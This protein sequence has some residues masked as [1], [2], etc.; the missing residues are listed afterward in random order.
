[1][2]RRRPD[3]P[4]G[5]PVEPK[6]IDLRLAAGA[7]IAWAAVLATMS[8]TSTEIAY[9]VLVAGL[10]GCTA[11]AANWLFAWA[12]GPRS[13]SVL[14]TLALIALCTAAVLSALLARVHQVRD[15]PLSTLVGARATGV[16]E[17]TVAGDPGPLGGSIGGAGAR[18]AIDVTVT[19]VRSGSRSYGLTAPAVVVTSEAGWAT[20]APGQ[21]IRLDGRLGPPWSPTDLIASVITARGPPTLVGQPP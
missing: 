7:V 20:L 3:P 17:A 16:V 6:E 11:L 8:R 21:R 2:S 1:M 9:A 19:G 10:V 4:E 5:E 14:A 12:I 13:K 18:L 15:G